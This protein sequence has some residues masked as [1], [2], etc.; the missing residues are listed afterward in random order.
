MVVELSGFV[1]VV[2]ID[3]EGAAE[4]GSLELRSGVKNTDDVESPVIAAVVVRPDRGANRN[5]VADFPAIFLGKGP[6][7]ECA[8]ARR[9]HGLDLLGCEIEFRIDDRQ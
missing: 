2:I 4:R 9:L 7:D 1:P 5:L 8:G 3:P 6:A